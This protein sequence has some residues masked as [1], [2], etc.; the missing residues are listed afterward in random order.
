MPDLSN[1]WLYLKFYGF[2][3]LAA[4]LL[5]MLFWLGVY[6]LGGGRD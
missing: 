1:I 6:L 5:V 3:L 4:W 2:A